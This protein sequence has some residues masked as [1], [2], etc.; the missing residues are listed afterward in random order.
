MSK[1][2]ISI[3]EL[4]KD[5]ASIPTYIPKSKRPKEDTNSNEQKQQPLPKFQSSSTS[6]KTKP[7]NRI[8]SNIPKLEPIRQSYEPKKKNKKFQFDWDDSEDTS[9]GFNPS[10]V[11]NEEEDNINDPLLKDKSIGHWSTKSVQEM[12]ERDWRIFNEDYGITVKNSNNKNNDSNTPNPIRSWDESKL[13][14]KIVDLLYNFGFETPTPIQR[15]SIPIAI[16]QRDLVGIAET[17]SGKTLAFL[18]PIFNYLLS[19]DSNYLKYEKVKNENLVLILAPTRELALQIKKEAENFCSK[20]GFNVLSIIGG[21][22]YQ[23]TINEIALKGCDIIVGTPGRLIDS[24]EKKLFDLSKCYYLVMDEADRMIDMGFEK[25]LNKLYEYLPTNTK[26]QNS[27]DTRIFNLKNKI[28]MMYTAT[29]TPIITKLTKSFLIDPVY[30]TIGGAGEALNNIDQRFELL[31]N[32]Q[33]NLE[34]IK[35]SKLIKL[36]QSHNYKNPN[37]LIIIFAN[38]KDTVDNLSV[39]LDSRNFKTTTIHGSKTQESRE[40]ALQQFKNYE[41]PI[42]I[43]TDIAARGID[44]SNVNLVI[45]FQMPKQFDEYIH[46]IGRTGRAGKFGESFSFIN[47]EN[48][49]EIFIPLKKFLKKGGKKLPEW[50]Y[51]YN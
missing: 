18:L 6:N 17:G 33:S 12:T 43:A 35:I 16:E 30:I 51:R 45:N 38:F 2:P 46:R 26:L 29:I 28:T 19:I 27:I 25:D 21:H 37:S 36:I 31:S 24:I 5:D 10:L 23:D 15:S 14:S 41:K 32:K 40:L 8:A 20:L 13:N 11:D 49:K 50:L 47:D 7:Q 4:L 3:D 34:S 22:Q 9:N 1:R 48:D 44:V 42:L 39:E